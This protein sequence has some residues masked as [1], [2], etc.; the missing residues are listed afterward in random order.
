MAQ[1]VGDGGL[2]RY[3]SLIDARRIAVDPYQI[4]RRILVDW[5]KGIG[6][7]V[8]NHDQ[9][10]SANSIGEGQELRV[11][12]RLGLHLLESEPRLDAESAGRLWNTFVGQGPASGFLGGLN[13]SGRDGACT[14]DDGDSLLLATSFHRQGCH[15]ER[16]TDQYRDDDQ[17][18]D[19]RLA[20]N[21]L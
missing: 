7:N 19:I 5:P 9:L 18:D 8:H 21:G 1:T 6:R 3:A 4:L 13:H 20:Q 14:V 10:A 16:T 12:I 2:H 11:L 17:T 15:H